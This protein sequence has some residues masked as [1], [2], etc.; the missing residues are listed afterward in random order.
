MK[1]TV[2]SVIIASK[3]FRELNILVDKDE[4]HNSYF[5]TKDIKMDISFDINLRAVLMGEDN[6]NDILINFIDF[7]E[8]LDSSRSERMQS[9]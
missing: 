3:D 6:G 5:K 1:E 4:V 7:L 2:I 9:K 8:M